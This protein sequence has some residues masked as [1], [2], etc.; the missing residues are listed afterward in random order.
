MNIH[1]ICN[2]IADFHSFLRRFSP[3][4]S[5]SSPRL[6]WVWSPFHLWYP[7]EQMKLEN[8]TTTMTKKIS[9]KK[10]NAITNV[11]DEIILIL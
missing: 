9:K 8:M 7:G 2:I 6:V 4:F 5:S 3:S 11:I 1:P 10:M